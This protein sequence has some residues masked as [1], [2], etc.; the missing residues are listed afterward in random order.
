M[1][2]LLVILIYCLS[3]HAF[4]NCELEQDG[5][6][7]IATYTEGGRI[8]NNQYIFYDLIDPFWYF[9][10][11]N[12]SYESNKSSSLPSF[13]VIDLVF[14]NKVCLSKAKTEGVESFS[15]TPACKDVVLNNVVQSKGFAFLEIDQKKIHIPAHLRGALVTEITDREKKIAEMINEYLKKNDFWL[16]QNQVLPFD[17]LKVLKIDHYFFN[18][19]FSS[20]SVE[21]EAQAKGSFFVVFLISNDNLWYVA[22]SSGLTRCDGEPKLGVD[23]KGMSAHIEEGWDFNGDNVPDLIKFEEHD[24]YYHIEFGKEM[25]VLKDMSFRI[26]MRHNQDHGL[27]PKK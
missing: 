11:F 27:K 1:R 3:L 20:A 12:R 24:I 2:R 26:V 21:V 23:R 14:E 10:A 5:Y 17:K 6:H 22:D 9:R 13:P 15:R 18:P 7:T 19:K 16:S 8:N 25:V 4:A